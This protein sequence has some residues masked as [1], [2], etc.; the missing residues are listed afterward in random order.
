MFH[1]E[2]Y[3]YILYM[4]IYKMNKLCRRLDGHQTYSAPSLSLHDLPTLCQRCQCDLEL[5]IIT[6]GN[7][8]FLTQLSDSNRKAAGSSGGSNTHPRHDELSAQ[9][10]DL[11]FHLAADVEL[12]TVQGDSLQVG[13]QVLLAR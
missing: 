4:A 5:K 7:I 10:L 13:Q 8:T 11:G 12:M 3:T 9:I 1:L 2:Q 6:L